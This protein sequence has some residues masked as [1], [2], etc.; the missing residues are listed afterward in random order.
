MNFKR[1]QK[2]LSVFA[3]SSLTDI[4]F[5][6]IIFFLLTSSFVIQPG[7][8]VLLPQSE[9]A[10]QEPQGRITISITEKGSIY[11]NEE[12]V[13]IETLGGKLAMLLPPGKEDVVVINADKNVSLQSAVQLMDIAKGVGATRLLIATQQT[14]M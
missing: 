7:I 2:L 11:L 13:S 10:E 5:L 8:K 14:T 4:V 12:L 1:E 6:L 3:Y 9:Q